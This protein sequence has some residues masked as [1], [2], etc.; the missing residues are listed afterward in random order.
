MKFSKFVSIKVKNIKKRP[1]EV[2]I[3][4]PLRSCRYYDKVTEGT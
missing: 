1:K 3:N 2:G 4:F